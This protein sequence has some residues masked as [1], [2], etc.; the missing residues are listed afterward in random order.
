MLKAGTG[1]W[2]PAESL[3]RD[4]RTTLKTMGPAR[5]D[6]ALAQEIVHRLLD[7]NVDTLR[8]AV[9]IGSRRYG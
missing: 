7:A 6:L 4:W 5:G 9:I 2:L 3:V 8:R 1:N